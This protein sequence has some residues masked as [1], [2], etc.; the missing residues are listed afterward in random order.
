[1]SQVLPPPPVDFSIVIVNWNTCTLLKNCLQSIEQQSKSSSFEIIVIDNASSDG[2]GQLVRS[3]FPHVTLIENQENIG[4][5]Q[6]NNQGIRQSQGRYLVLLNPDTILLN[7]ILFEFQQIFDS[8]P[9]I[10]IAGAN[11]ITPNNKSQRWSRGKM[12]SLRTTFNHYFF[13]SDLFSHS[14]IF[15]GLTDNVAHPVLTDLD[16][17][18]GACLAVR[19]A[20]LD[21]AGMFDESIFMYSED[22]ELCYRV[23]QA[24]Y[25]VVY[26]PTAQVK[27]FVGQGMKQQTAE[28][29]LSAPL[30]SLD[31]LYQHLYGQVG[32]FPF[33]TI[34][35]LGTS[36]RFI[37]RLI[38]FMLNRDE[39][40]RYRLSE[41]KRN[42]RTAWRLWRGA[43]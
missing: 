5:A 31:T 12:L 22:M 43:Y 36:V 25:R 35:C 18:S 4:F 20:A 14:R 15:P 34:I 24:G 41:A 6:A 28:A 27:H 39:K 42:I 19:R 11:L 13:L 23:K 9:D 2:S 10:G 1:M 7:D 16:W 29:I 32:L 40:N 21:Q 33:R 3:Q 8:Q 17:V 30:H 26:A 37:F 38:S